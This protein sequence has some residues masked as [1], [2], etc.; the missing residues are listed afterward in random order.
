MV[1]KV[2]LD[3]LEIEIGALKE[4]GII[5]EEVPAEP[6]KRKIS[7]WMLVSLSVFLLLCVTG[8]SLWVYIKIRSADVYKEEV[9][10][11]EGKI[12]NFDNFIIGLRDDQGNY[13]VLICDISFELNKDAEI[14]G[15]RVNVRRTIYKAV[16]RKKVGQVKPAEVREILK[17][18]IRFEL[19]NFLGEEIV[20]RVYFARFVLL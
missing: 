10:V 8:T 3:F 4:A 2:E 1:R 17:K 12:E 13:R 7:L 6:E 5:R 9:S 16:I 19:N 14:S 11:L 15:K 20:K 18:T